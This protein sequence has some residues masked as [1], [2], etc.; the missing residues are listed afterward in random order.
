MKELSLKYIVKEPKK[1]SEDTALLL[2]LHGYGS[3]EQ[4]LFS[5]AQ[6]LDEN[7]LIISTQ[8]P[9]ELGFN[10]YAWYTINF[11]T[12][13]GNYSD[14][15]EAIKSREKIAIFID[16]LQQLY[17]I[18]PSNTILLGFSQGTILSYAIALNYPKKVQKVIALSG[19]INEKLLSGNL[20]DK[21]YH[22]LDFFISHGTVDQVIP[23]SWAEKAPSFLQKLGIKTTFKTYPI[24]HGVSPPNFF[25]FKKWLEERV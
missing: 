7:L 9:L 13:N 4:D 3:N 5:F 6:E 24:G 23:I 8:A 20:E 2:L 16:E 15:P 19:Y 25:D 17:K 12:I 14:I 1:Y 22:L 10:S 11:D 18:K 21:D